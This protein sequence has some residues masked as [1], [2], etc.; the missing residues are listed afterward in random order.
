MSESKAQ[1]IEVKEGERAE[2][3]VRSG[4]NGFVLVVSGPGR[5]LD[6]VI[7]SSPGNNERRKRAAIDWLLPSL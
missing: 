5:S 1:R 6:V 7:S 2:V 4:E 3:C